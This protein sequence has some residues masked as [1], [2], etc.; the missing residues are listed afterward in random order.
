MILSGIGIIGSQCA[1]VAPSYGTIVQCFTSNGTWSCSTGSTVCVEVVAIG[2]GAGGRSGIQFSSNPGRV[3]GGPGGGAG[4]VSVCT[5]TSGFGT[6]QCVIIGGGGASDT[7]GSATCFGAL[8]VAG[9]GQLGAVVASSAGVG[10]S[11]ASGGAGG[12]GNQ[13]TAPAGGGTKA[14]ADALPYPGNSAIPEDEGNPGSSAA[15]FPGGGGG[16]GG[17]SACGFGWYGN[18][19]AGAAG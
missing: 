7:A 9:G 11:T 4:G 10:S 19:G 16:G 2:G 13:G 17:F 6:S 1:T 12:T 18:G 8:V 5:L 3:T 14:C 15:G